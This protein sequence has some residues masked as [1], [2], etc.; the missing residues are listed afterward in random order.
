MRDGWSID[1][2]P[3]ARERVLRN[4]W[5]WASAA[6]LF[7][8]LAFS[9]YLKSDVSQVASPAIYDFLMVAVMGVHVMLRIRFPKDLGWP[10]LLWGLIFF[11]YA[12]GAL[13]A[14]FPHRSRDFMLVMV[15]LV[16]SFAFFAAVIYDDPKRRLPAIWWGYVAAAFIASAIGLAAYF[17]VMPGAERYLKFGRVT[18]L[19][20][21]PNVFGAFLV[22][23]ILFL[24]MRLS[25]ARSFKELLLVPLLGVLVL[26]IFLCFSRGA[27]ANLVLSGAIFM[28]LAFIT[29]RSA[30]Q[31]FRIVLVMLFAA[32][33][34]VLIVGWALS[35]DAVSDLFAQRFS[36][37]QSYD[38]GADGRFDRQLNALAHGLR[39]PLGMGPAQWEQET[40]LAPHNVYLNILLAGGYLS[41]LAYL[42][43]IGLTL[44][45]GTAAAFRDAGSAYQP[46]LI[47]TVAAVTGQAAESIII[48]VDNWRHLYLLFGLAWGGIALEARERRQ[49]YAEWAQQSGARPAPAEGFYA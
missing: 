21:D 5:E 2:G 47:V 6:L 20:N 41:L 23:P 8:L 48:D 16:A 10:V 38:V 36:L 7:V 40:G 12:I 9:S 19:F 13:D 39:D 35:S 34:G 4:P 33:G 26:A 27:W 43:F 46:Y 14:L 17:G 1:S 11:G 25:L 15:Y 22:A 37:S 29:S 44:V 31:R 42:A 28:A 45:R 49:K 30:V 24:A 32:A 18:S 3:Q